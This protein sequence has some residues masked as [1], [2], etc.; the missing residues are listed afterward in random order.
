VRS[1][2]CSVRCAE[3]APLTMTIRKFPS[4][5]PMRVLIPLLTGI[6]GAVVLVLFTLY[7]SH[8][9]LAEVEEEARHDL[10][11]IMS[12]LQGSVNYLLRR[13]DMTGVQAVL[14]NEGVHD[15]I[16]DVVL[17]DPAGTIRAASRPAANGLPL[18]LTIPEL[19]HVFTMC[20]NGKLMGKH[21]LS[22][23]KNHLLGCYPVNSINREGAG[24]PQS[25]YLLVSYD[26]SRGKM[27]G[28]QRATRLALLVWSLFGAGLLLLIVLLRYALARRRIALVLSATEKLAAG[29]VTA[30]VR[31]RGGDELATISR[32]FDRMAD[33]L[34]ATTQALETSR[35][36][37]EQRVQERTA[38]LA[39]TNEMLEREI[40]V[41]IHAEQAARRDGDWLRSLIE[42]SQDAVI[43]ID[44]QAQIVLFNPS[45]ERIFGYTADEVVGRKINLLMAEPYA[46]EHDGYISDYQRTG[47]ARAI[48]QT[49][50]FMAKR[51][52]GEQFPIE[53]SLTEVAADENVPYAAFIRDVSEKSRL[54]AQLLESERLA[55]I[56]TTAAKIGHE[57][58]NPLNGMYLT[59]QLLEQRLAKELAGSNGQIAANIKKLR[60]EIGR[61]NQL[62]QQFRALAR[63]E[64]LEFR[65]L[66]IADLIKDV[67]T[68]QQPLCASLGIEIEQCLAT[69][70]PPISADPDKL[71]QAILNLLK[72]SVE[73]M[74]GGGKIRITGSAT[75]DTVTIELAD[76]GIGVPPDIDIFQ[77]FATT[78]DQ[79]T[80]LGL[81]IVRQIIT[82]HRGTISYSSEPGK[83]TVF[84]ISL[85]RT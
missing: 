36:G 54:Q 4:A 69:D 17:V 39:K 60:D 44:R 21:L 53:V 27:L 28:E 47:K 8:K 15:Y 14:T 85:P 43:S 78:K 37:L 34:Q 49:R 1:R 68:V 79:G 61:L 18:Q 56:G 62:L 9:T 66:Y 57:M 12:S 13:N 38:E 71:K 23:D 19:A 25:G 52:N 35:A 22:F 76:T 72:N 7:Q 51:K 24:G 81:V 73:A 65:D 26:F 82:A 59:V 45:A 40:T 16:N 80:G 84:V 70:L 2:L 63:R 58:A 10:A 29:D 41:R 55:A 74:P 20:R 6:G 42:T 30:R 11:S 33:Q 32:A 64:K 5:L 48:G 31:L 83:G 3:Y 46:W 67:V 77:P 50:L 75:S